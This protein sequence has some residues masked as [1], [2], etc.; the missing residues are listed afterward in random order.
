MKKSCT[1]NMINHNILNCCQDGF[2]F[3]ISSERVFSPQFYSNHWSERDKSEQS[4]TGETKLKNHLC[5]ACRMKLAAWSSCKHHYKVYY[6][7]WRNIIGDAA[8]FFKISAHRWMTGSLDYWI[9]DIE[10]RIGCII[11]IQWLV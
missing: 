10:Y 2:S 11:L 4:G 9:W 7:F 6:V 3:V 1:L 5:V 8:R